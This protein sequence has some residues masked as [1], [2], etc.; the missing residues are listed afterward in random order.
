MFSYCWYPCGSRLTLVQCMPPWLILLVLKAPNLVT[1]GKPKPAP[2]SSDGKHEFNTPSQQASS[3]MILLIDLGQRRAYE[4]GEQSSSC[5]PRPWETG[6]RV[7]HRQKGK[8]E[9]AVFIR[10]QDMGRFE[11]MGKCHGT[12]LC[13]SQRGL[14]ATLQYHSGVLRNGTRRQDVQGVKENHSGG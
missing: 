7:S 12:Y 4:S 8:W 13:K 2:D 5:I 3:S 9:L 11:L 10:E 14:W 1:H 6:M